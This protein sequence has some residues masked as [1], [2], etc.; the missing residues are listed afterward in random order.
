MRLHLDSSV[1]SASGTGQTNPGDL[2]TPG[3]RSTGQNG[4]SKLD[5]IQISGPSSALN[6][7]AADRALRIQQLTA[8][9][10]NG[11]YEI[12]SSAISSALVAYRLS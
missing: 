12:P 11:S 3:S 5:T 6:R 10:Q 7:L 4:S 1:T 2:A 9:V 8:S